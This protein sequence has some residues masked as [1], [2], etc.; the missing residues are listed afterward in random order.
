V[1]SC[2]IWVRGTPG[3]ASTLATGT[4]RPEPWRFVVDG[5]L[6]AVLER[7]AAP[8][9]ELVLYYPSRSQALPKLR[10]FVEHLREER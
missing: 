7:Y 3:C 5:E 10:A 9:P 8:L 1:A 2:C 4:P 6:V